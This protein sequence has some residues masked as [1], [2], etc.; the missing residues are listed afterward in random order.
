MGAFLSS[1]VGPLLKKAGGSLLGSFMGGGGGGG[2]GLMGGFKNMLGSFM[3]GGGGGGK[4]QQ[5]APQGQQQGGQNPWVMRPGDPGMGQSQTMPSASVQIPHI[6]PM[7]QYT[8]TAPN[9]GYQNQPVVSNDQS[10]TGQ[11]YP[12]P[13]DGQLPYPQGYK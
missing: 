12:F 6:S 5:Y 7:P 2:G 3:G 11:S 13:Q 1:M 10:A 9:S 8:P 4:T